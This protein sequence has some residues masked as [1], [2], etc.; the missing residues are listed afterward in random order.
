TRSKR[1]WSSDVCSSDLGGFELPDDIGATRPALV[2]VEQDDEQG[3]RVGRAVVGRMRAFLEGGQLA[4][5]HLVQDLSRL[6][7]AERID[8]SRSEERRVGKE[9]QARRA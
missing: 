2:L 4:E 7:V 9:G 8:R 1:D 3:R 5:A 6:G